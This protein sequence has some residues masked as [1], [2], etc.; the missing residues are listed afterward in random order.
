[1]IYTMH[2]CILNFTK[3]SVRSM[4]TFNLLAHLKRLFTQFRVSCKQ[5]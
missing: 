1:M 5:M 2:M 3:M 4:Y